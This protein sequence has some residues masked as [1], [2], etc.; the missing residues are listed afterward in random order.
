MEGP[1]WAQDRFELSYM[2]AIVNAQCPVGF[3]GEAC[4]EDAEQLKLITASAETMQHKAG[5]EVNCLG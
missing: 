2:T 5:S 3:N 1:F 4:R